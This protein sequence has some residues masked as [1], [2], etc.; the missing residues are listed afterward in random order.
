[1][2]TT[3]TMMMI[4]SFR[5]L[6]S[7]P[8]LHEVSSFVEGH[9]GHE[10]LSRAIRG[11]SMRSGHYNRRRGCAPVGRDRSGHVPINLALF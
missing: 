3:T 2:T 4:L 5:L 8:E 1:M 7:Q 11:L 6:V 10:I 9:Y